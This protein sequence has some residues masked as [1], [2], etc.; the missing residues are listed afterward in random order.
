MFGGG[1]AW[2]RNAARIDLCLEAEKVESVVK[3]RDFLL[4]DLAQQ[5]NDARGLS[6]VNTGLRKRGDHRDIEGDIER[7][8]DETMEAL[9][10]LV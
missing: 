10:T 6:G 1:D 7:I 5:E 4:A 2:V 8:K 3:L 9:K